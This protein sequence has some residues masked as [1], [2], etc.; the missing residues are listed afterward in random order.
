[1]EKFSVSTHNVNYLTKGKQKGDFF[2]SCLWSIMFYLT[3]IMY[4]IA[5]IIPMERQK[6][7]NEHTKVLQTF[8][9]ISLQTH[10]FFNT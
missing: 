4:R 1:M 8:E 6:K 2:N 7:L 9:Y 3:S 5:Y 10:S